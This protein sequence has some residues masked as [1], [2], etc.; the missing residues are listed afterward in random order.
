MERLT[1]AEKELHAGGWKITGSVINGTVVRYHVYKKTV[2]SHKWYITGQNRERVRESAL[3]YMQRE[4]LP[5]TREYTEGDFLIMETDR[6]R[7]TRSYELNCPGMDSAKISGKLII[8]SRDYIFQ[9]E[10][11]GIK[12]ELYGPSL[13]AGMIISN[14]IRMKSPYT[15]ISYII[16]EEKK[17]A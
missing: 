2:D 13:R 4:C 8:R 9:F 14:I 17:E 10:H 1:A 15:D 5:I 12:E 11:D 3:R 16:T 6:V 7:D